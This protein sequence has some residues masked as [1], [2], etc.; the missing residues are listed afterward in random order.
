MKF[1]PRTNLPS[2]RNFTNVLQSG[3]IVRYYSVGEGNA[4]VKL[5]KNIKIQSQKGGPFPSA[6]NVTFCIV[7]LKIFLIKKS[8]FLL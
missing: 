6:V 3:E 4:L 1:L 8:L 7:I 5:K 2:F